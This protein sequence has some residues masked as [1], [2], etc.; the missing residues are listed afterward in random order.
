MSD[1][2]EGNQTMLEACV[3]VMLAVATSGEAPVRTDAALARACDVAQ[4]RAAP[5][6][7]ARTKADGRS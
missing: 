5:A 4:V 2:T 1:L 3:V 7:A 6:P